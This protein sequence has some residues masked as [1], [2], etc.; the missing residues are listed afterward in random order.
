M[1]CKEDIF[2]DIPSST[3]AKNSLMFLPNAIK[4]KTPIKYFKCTKLGYTITWKPVKC[5]ANILS[6]WT[7]PQNSPPQLY[8]RELNIKGESRNE[9][10]I[11]TVYYYKHLQSKPCRCSHTLVQSF[12]QSFVPHRHFDLH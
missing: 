11:P 7:F 1:L 5:A 9:K 8:V 3:N 2:S 4:K 12:V 10:K 6:F